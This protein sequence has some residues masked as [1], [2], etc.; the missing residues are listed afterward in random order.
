MTFTICAPKVLIWND[1][2]SHTKPSAINVEV[3]H[4]EAHGIRI[5]IVIDYREFDKWW[6]GESIY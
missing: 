2:G 3:L 6:G 1:L 5:W 4:D